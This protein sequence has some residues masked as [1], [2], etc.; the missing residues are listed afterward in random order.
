MPLNIFC[1]PV[2]SRD[3]V[4]AQVSCGGIKS[5]NDVPCLQEKNI[6][7]ASRNFF[8]GIW[9]SKTLGSGSPTLLCLL[10]ALIGGFRPKHPLM[11]L[12]M[13]G[14]GPEGVRLGSQPLE[15][16]GTVVGRVPFSL[17]LF[18][19]HFVYCRRM[20]GCGGLV[21]YVYCVYMGAGC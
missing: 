11:D 14:R 5:Q 3:E 10:C 13:L 4:K 18:L 8:P 19:L 1:Q 9:T 6:L 17:G 20:R 21:E 16:L 12:I 15:T 2:L 7:G